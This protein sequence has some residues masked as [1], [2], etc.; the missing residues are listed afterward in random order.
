RP[1]APATIVR[2]RIAIIS[3]LAAVLTP[4]LAARV[5]LRMP[6]VSLHIIE[7]G[8]RDIELKLGRGEADMAVYLASTQGPGE[9]PLAT[10]QL[11]FLGAASPDA[12]EEGIA[13]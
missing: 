5:G 3:S 2:L 8:T 4:L 9:Q 12:G 6:D 7:A 1:A 13:L 10:E 11:F